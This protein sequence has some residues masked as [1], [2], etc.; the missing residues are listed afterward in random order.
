V[1]EEKCRERRKMQGEKKNVGREG[2][3]SEKE[4]AVREGKCKDRR[5]M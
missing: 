5:K 3:C 2:K 4:N 1:R